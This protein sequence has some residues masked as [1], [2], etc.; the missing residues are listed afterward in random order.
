MIIVVVVTEIK[1]KDDVTGKALVFVATPI[2]RRKVLN[3]SISIFSSPWIIDSN[4][5]NHITCDAKKIPFLKPSSQKII[6]VVYGN[7]T[8]QL[9]GKNL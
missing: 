8:S 9:L 2:N 7:T 1:I 5:T 6:S 4:V 3:K